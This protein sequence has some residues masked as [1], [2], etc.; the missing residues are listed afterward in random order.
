MK[1]LVKTQRGP[2]HLALRQVDPRPLGPD[3]VRVEVRAAGLCGSDWHIYQDDAPLALNPPVTL[4]HE[5]AGVIVEAGA[6][7]SDW[8]LGERVTSETTYQTCGHCW[9]CTHGR[10]NLC[11]AKR[12]LGYWVDGAFAETVVVPARGLHRLPEGVDFVAGALTEPLAC[13]AHAVLEVAP[14]AEGETV[15][16]TG[17]GAIGLLALQVAQARGARVWV[18]GAA[19]DEARLELAQSWGVAGV[20]N[21]ED[22]DALAGLRESVGAEG[23]DLS[24]ECSGAPGALDLCLHA[25][26]TGGTVGAVGLYGHPV[27]VDFDQIA[28]RELVVRGSFSSTPE[29]WEAALD[30]LA[31]GAIHVEEMVSELLPLEEWEQAFRRYRERT[32]L[33]IMLG[34]HLPGA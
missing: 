17:P 33:K 1:A 10:G 32:D 5:F 4:G 9:T 16:I 31:A 18:A 28:R 6:D 15:L 25:T 22:P 8:S 23:V 19:G 21:A 2:G 3:E 12:T 14:P 26:R 27:E 24:Y 30:L 7:V 20:L 13:V 34:P 11:P 29:S